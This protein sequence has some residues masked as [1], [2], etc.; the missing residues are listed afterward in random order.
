[1]CEFLRTLGAFVLA[2]VGLALWLMTID[3]YNG[4]AAGQLVLVIQFSPP[5]LGAAAA[6][7][8]RGDGFNGTLRYWSQVLCVNIKTDG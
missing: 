8:G 5:G 4:T 7:N 6:F 3:E 2:L 1:M